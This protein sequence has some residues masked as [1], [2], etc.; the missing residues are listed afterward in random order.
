MKIVSINVS[1]QKGTPKTSVESAEFKVNQG[2]VGDAHAG[3]GEKQVSLLAK[4]SHELF[5]PMTDVCLKNGI[6]GENITTKGIELHKLNVCD[7]LQIGGV[8]LQITKIGKEC[9]APCYIAKNVG[10]CIMPQRGV[11]AKVLSNGKIKK[12]DLIIVE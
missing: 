1:K 11:F 5:A 8:V 2:I 6:F 4:E 10:S 9:H 3:P 7:R 12:N